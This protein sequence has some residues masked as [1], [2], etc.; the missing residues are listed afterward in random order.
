MKDCYRE[1]MP[2]G[3]D[4]SRYSHG[5]IGGS[6]M[7][8]IDRCYRYG[9][10]AKP[11]KAEYLFLPFSDHFGH[12]VTFEVA[13]PLSKLLLPQSRP[14]FKIKPDTI[15]D[16]I[17]QNRISDASK[18]WGELMKRGI[19]ISFLWEEIIKKEIRSIAIER[20]REITWEKRGELNL[21]FLRMNYLAR[22]L[23]KGD[24]SVLSSLKTIQKLIVEWY[25]KE[26]QKIILQSKSNECEMNEK[27]RIY[28]HSLH[29]KTIRKG[30]ILKLQTERGLLT[31]HQECANYLEDQVQTLL[32]NKHPYK[33]GSRDALL[34]FV[35]KVFT[36]T[37]NKML[38]KPPTQDEIYKVISISNQLA[39]PGTDGI[40][41]FFYKTCWSYIK[42]F[43]IAMIKCFHD[44]G[45]T[46][47]SQKI[48]MMVFMCKPKYLDSLKP[49]HKRRISLLNT[50]FKIMSGIESLRFSSIATRII[51]PLQLVAG[52]DRRIHHGICRARDTIRAAAN[53][54]GGCGIV[55]SDFEAGFDWLTLEWLWLVLQAKG[56]D[57]RVI[58]RLKRLY[59]DRITLVVVNNTIGAK[60][61]NIRGSLAQGDRPSMIFFCLGL[62][63]LLNYLEQKLEGIKLF[64]LPT[65][66]PI[67][68]GGYQEAKKNHQIS[69]LG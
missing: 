55:D 53:I 14:T 31:G 64:S 36:D 49:G 32:L 52:E 21:L 24:L 29:A 16:Q 17:F 66:G 67:D 10:M 56:C 69:Q 38:L 20:G 5:S 28:H 15:R 59:M 58:E 42:D 8:R 40:P 30:S 9:T 1:L 44:G 39:S 51:S 13:E 68:E 7:S 57:Q 35:P 12:I 22:A 62:D 47:K 65:A 4:F 2:K 27:V 26:S 63:P 50:C 46:S 19:N 25:E 18:S 34:N 43:L 23:Q 33:Q 54:K 11:I 3:R 41:Y 48:S 37:D 60:I 61:K 45:N 6:S